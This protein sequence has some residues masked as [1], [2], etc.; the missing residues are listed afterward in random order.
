VSTKTH[1]NLQ[2]TTGGATSRVSIT[3]RGAA[4]LLR[5]QIWLWPLLAAGFL[6]VIGWW[7]QYSIEDSMQRQSAAHLQ[8]L[9]A[10]DVDALQTWLKIAEKD[11]AEAAQVREVR[12]GTE[13][14][15]EVLKTALENKSA[16]LD[17]ELLNDP[18]YE[19]V[20]KAVTS[21]I[22]ELGYDDFVLIAADGRL[23]VSG[24]N[25]LIGFEIKGE[26]RT[27]IDKVLQGGP[28]VSR[29]TP[30][31]RPIIDSTTG[32]VRSGVPIMLTGAPVLSNEDQPIA[33][34]ALRMRPEGEFSRILTAARF[35]NSGETYAFNEKGVLLSQSRFDPELKR[36]GLLE[37]KPEITSILN[38][39]MR[40]PGV[41]LT[42][43]ARP[44]LSRSEMPLTKTAEQAISGSSG[45]DMLGARD[46][47]GVPSVVAWTWLPRYNFGV[48]TKVEYNEVFAPLFT[49]RR[50]IWLLLGLL[51]LGAVAIYL[52][53]ILLQR[54]QRE[55]Q[56][57]ALSAK[58][59]G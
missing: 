48:A 49:V 38:L 50:F 29:P 43:G 54:Q 8:A 34:L 37:D 33:V 35:G 5:S 15:I 28:L 7:V 1:V 27:F 59:L 3:L 46:Y 58:Q 44:K 47:R 36:L 9:L 18:Y 24:D 41:D 56:K 30:S 16:N 55:L 2:R 39:E 53:M 11:A 52:F 45:V 20:Q 14:L 57:A 6:A 26:R 23:L 40:D 32:E 10:V 25:Q 51:A 19:R 22:T 12:T 4:R 31:I 42:T 21:R 13:Q 17:R